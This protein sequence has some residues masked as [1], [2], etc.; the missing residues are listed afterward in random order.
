MKVIVMHHINYGGYEGNS[1]ANIDDETCDNK[2]SGGD[3]DEDDDTNLIR[4]PCDVK[5]LNTCMAGAINQYYINY[6]HKEPC[7]VSYNTGMRWLTEIL[8]GYWTRCVNMCRMDKD[9][10]LSLCNDLE[11]HYGL[12]AS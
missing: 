3:E 10:L 5:K 11:T 4:R 2:N 12:K 6:I 7:M 9:T 1:N 8:R